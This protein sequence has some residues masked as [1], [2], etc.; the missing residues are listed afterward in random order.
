MAHCR[1]TLPR[2]FS[3]SLTLTY[4]IRWDPR[5]RLSMC[6]LTRYSDRYHRRSREVS[7]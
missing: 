1:N 7:E 4:I 5:D 3:G 6:S 2:I